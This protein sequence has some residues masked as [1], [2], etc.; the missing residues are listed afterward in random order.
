MFGSHGKVDSRKG[1][2]Q[3]KK[4]NILLHGG[5]I[6]KKE[7]RFALQLYAFV[8]NSA[9]NQCVWYFYWL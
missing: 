4:V 5:S 7:S 6:F 9:P 8:E 3:G 1:L 2:L